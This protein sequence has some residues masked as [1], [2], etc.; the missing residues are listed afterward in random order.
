MEQSTVNHHST[1]IPG[2]WLRA[3]SGQLWGKT[4]ASSQKGPPFPKLLRNW[5]GFAT[6]L[7]KAMTVPGLNSG[8]VIN[9]NTLILI[10]TIQS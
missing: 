1:L 2:L 4:T 8:L 7:P 5:A 9:Q 3:V 6:V 10:L